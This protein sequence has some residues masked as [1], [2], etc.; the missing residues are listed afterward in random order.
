LFTRRLP[1]VE[2]NNATFE[3]IIKEILKKTS[4]LKLKIRDASKNI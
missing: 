2:F 1:R 3:N 4:D